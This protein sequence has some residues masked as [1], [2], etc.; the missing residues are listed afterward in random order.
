[1]IQSFEIE[2]A[3]QKLRV[4]GDY[5]EHEPGTFDD[6]GSSE[7]FECEKIELLTGISIT[8]RSIFLDI[9]SFISEIAPELYRTVDKKVIEMLEDKRK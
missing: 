3:G 7:S 2:I 1:M 6:P 8:N 9:S 4:T 5:S